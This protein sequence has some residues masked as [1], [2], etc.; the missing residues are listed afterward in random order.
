MVK[1]EF[2]TRA[3]EQS[4][5]NVIST[6]YMLYDYMNHNKDIF[7]VDSKAI[8]Y[9]SADHILKDEKIKI[10]LGSLEYTYTGSKIIPEVNVSYQLDGADVSLAE[11]RDYKLV[12][13]NNLNAATASGKAAPS[14]KV[15]GMGAF[16]GNS[17]LYKEKRGINMKKVKIGKSDIVASQLILGMMRSAAKDAANM[18]K[19]LEKAIELDINM[20]DH[21]DIYAAKEPAETIYGEVLKARPDLKDKFIVQTKCGIRPGFYDSSYEHIMKSVDQ[22][23]M[24]TGLDKIDILMISK[25]QNR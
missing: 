6:P 22:S 3:T 23:L 19:L 17:E 2:S 11:G 14:V 7:N 25:P 10:S 1:R 18:E 20:L 21:A 12:C 4:F 13:A 24:R 5:I 15:V 9:I 16:S 8:P